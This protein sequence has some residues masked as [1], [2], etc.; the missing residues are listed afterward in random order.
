MKT[1]YN[2]YHNIIHKEMWIDAHSNYN[3]KK[4]GDHRRLEETLWEGL[5]KRAVWYENSVEKNNISYDEY[6]D[7]KQEDELL[8]CIIDKK[9]NLKETENG[10]WGY[11]TTGKALVDLNFKVSSLRNAKESYIVNG[12]IK[13]FYESPYYA[14][15]W[16]FFL[17]DISQGLGERRTFQICMKYVAD[18]HPKLMKKLIPLI[19]QYGRY[20]DLLALLDTDLCN[21]TATFLQQ[22]ITKDLLSMKEQKPISL[23]AKWLPSINTSSGR[24]CN[25]A[26]ILIKNWG[27]NE[28]EYRKMLSSL[29]RYLDIVEVK[30]SASK[31]EEIDYE[32]IPAKANMMYE[33]AFEK[34]DYERREVYLN[35][36]IKGRAK[37]NA[38]G[39]MPHEI[40]HR[41]KRKNFYET[42]V[43]DNLMGE[44]MWQN[45]LQQGFEN[46]WGLEDC[47]VVADGSGSMYQCVSG[48]SKIRASEICSALAIYFAQQLQG[49]FH[50]KVIT[51]SE[52]PQFVNL[53]KGNNLKEKLEILLSHNEV[54]N[55]NIEAVF[56]LLLDLALENEVPKE[57]IP[58]SV[59][60][61]SDME[62]DAASTPKR[63]SKENF[64]K[65][66]PTLF[67]SIEEKYQKSGYPMPR[68]IFWNVCGRSNTIPK[69]DHDQGICL[70]SGFSQNAMKIA[71]NK[72]KKSPYESLIQALDSPRYKPVDLALKTLQM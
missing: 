21:E 64:H 26:K 30:M 18:S 39:I 3:L 1:E 33:A 43:K 42:T 54:A 57:M 65:F 71:A 5:M 60:I 13:A 67:Q 32:K 22:Q 6:E 28:K 56:E 45:L 24:S 49:V 46:N 72:E 4:F 50:D 38:K 2:E 8:Q 47:I 69:V 23:L 52:T 70:L 16:L 10:A 7:C 14:T 37:L 62:F 66:T 35:Q 19:P 12:F 29:R 41:F 48:N 15:K 9:F 55:T 20:D 51:F 17:R 34:H 44:L 25:Q 59:L 53:S 40:V 31:W 36:V 11:R 27:I 63:W 68:L 58:K 61:I